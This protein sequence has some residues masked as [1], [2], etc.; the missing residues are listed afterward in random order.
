MGDL[1]NPVHKGRLTLLRMH[2]TYGILF[3]SC[4]IHG[5]HDHDDH[6]E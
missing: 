1:V 3:L 5:C 6:E 2:T 4:D